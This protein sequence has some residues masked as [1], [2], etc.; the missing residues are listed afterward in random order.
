[1][2]S[3]SATVQ[4]ARPDLTKAGYLK[5]LLA[6]F[7]A[8]NGVGLLSLI[9][10]PFAVGAN[11]E[12]LGINESQAG[13]LGTLEFVGVVATSMFLAPRVGRIDR[14]R[15]ALGA[16]VFVIVM[17]VLCA[18]YG[19]Y[20]HLLL[21]RPLAGLGAGL[22]LATGNATIAMASKPEK[23]ASHMS[24]LFVALMVLVTLSFSALSAQF[25]QAGVY[26]G[27]AATIACLAPL[28]GWLPAVI[29][30]AATQAQLGP[31][32]A[33]SAF[34]KSGIWMV[35]AIFC[36]SMRDTMTWAFT[37]RIGASAGFQP[38]VIGQFLTAAAILGLAGPALAAFI[39][40]RFGLRTPLALGVIAA[41]TNTFALSQSG[42]NAYLFA[43]SVLCVVATYFFA[44]SFLNA[45]AAELDP[46]G[47]IVAAAGSAVMAGLAAAPVVAGYLW[48]AGGSGAIGGIV[49]LLLAIT[50][51][52]A[53]RAFRGLAQPHNTLN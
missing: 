33:G 1:M 22:A 46:E 26:M 39:G 30:D 38:G 28:Q 23:F 36:F 53:L 52:A 7:S 27:F 5:M 21:L 40:N 16:S 42:G 34:S 37:E 8:A 2:L 4:P 19:T 18:L 45:L 13:L 25:G 17:N 9:A 12:T 49:L 47:R 51:W 14:R 29:G 35:L 24:L 10:L 44:L 41:G 31:E 3:E 11:M 43:G 6:A 20:S 50:L 15:V 32:K 48:V